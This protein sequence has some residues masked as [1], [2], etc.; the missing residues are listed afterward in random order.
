MPRPTR[1][2][3]PPDPNLEARPVSPDLPC[4]RGVAGRRMERRHRGNHHGNVDIG[5]DLCRRGTRSVVAWRRARIVLSSAQGMVVDNIATV[6]CTSPDRARD[7]VHNLNADGFEAL[8]PEYRGGRPKTFTLLERGEIKKIAKSKPAGFL[9]DEGDRRHRP[10]GTVN[11]AP[12]GRRHLSTGEDLE[13]LERPG[14][15][16]QIGPGRTPLRHRRGEVVPEP[17]SASGLATW[18]GSGT[19]WGST[20]SATSAAVHR[21]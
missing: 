11:L 10:L 20:S 8:C 21:G 9:V 19:R 15:R 12:R 4:L 18:A 14:P 7:V 5:P 1:R 16:G 2:V 13:D 6:T 3:F 17:G